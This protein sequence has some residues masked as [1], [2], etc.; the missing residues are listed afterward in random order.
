MPERWSAH[1][2]ALQY[3]KLGRRMPEAVPDV[4]EHV[5]LAKV[6]RLARDLGYLPYHTHRSD[7]SEAGFPDLVLAKP[8]RLIF[9]ELKSA[10]GTTTAAQETWLSMLRHSITGLEV[11]LWR[12][13][14]L[15]QIAVIL[16]RKEGRGER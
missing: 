7:K 1:D 2:V 3:A 10:T 6:I 8:G 12:P 13:N 4:P 16:G 11:Y 14:D 9:A 5:F 15:P